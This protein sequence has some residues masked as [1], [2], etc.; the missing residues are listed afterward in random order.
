MIEE[1]LSRMELSDFQGKLRARAALLN[2]LALF[3][4]WHEAHLALVRFTG[5]SST[6]SGVTGLP[7]K[8]AR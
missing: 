6:W 5:P 1:A 7:S 2:A 8:I 4:R 3:L